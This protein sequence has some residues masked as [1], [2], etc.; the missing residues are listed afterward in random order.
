[1]NKQNYINAMNSIT[2]SDSFM[3]ET[4][5]LMKAARGAEAPKTKIFKFNYKYAAIAACAVLVIGVGA[6]AAAGALNSFSLGTKSSDCAPENAVQETAAGACAGE[7]ADTAAGMKNDNYGA[8]DASEEAA[9]DKTT[10]TSN[11][12]ESDDGVNLVTGENTTVAMAM[13]ETTAAAPMAT[14][15]FTMKYLDKRYVK[16]GSEKIEFVIENNTST[17]QG[18]GVDYKLEKNV[19]NGVWE[20]VNEDMAFIEIWEII[21]SGAS[22]NFAVSTSG[23]DIGEYRVTKK[24]GDNT[25]VLTFMVVTEEDY[26]KL[27]TG[28]YPIIEPA[29]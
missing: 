9:N 22:S 14:E 1:M 4:A 20:W 8:Y 10:I 26:A 2:V 21:P 23:L 6:F 3:S 16:A 5:E 11:A 19:G 28:T 17:E 13:P 24:L 25:T 18:F 27:E 7:I 15:E 12:G 29:P